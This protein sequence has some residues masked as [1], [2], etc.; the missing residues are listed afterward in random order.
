M[1]YVEAHGTGTA[2]GDPI[3]VQALSAVF[4]A[5]RETPLRLGS[6]KTNIGHLET[7]AGIAGLM[8]VV[9]AL[10]HEAIPPHLHLTRLNPHIS[11]GP[12]AEAGSHGLAAPI[13][14]PTQLTPWPRG[15]TPRLAGVS[16]FGFSGTNAHVIVE[17]APTASIANSSPVAERQL[18]LLALSAR[19]EAALRAV[20][21]RYAEALAT[22]PA[23]RLGDF[24]FS[25]HTGRA[26]FAHRLAV[27]G[28]DAAEI[29]QQLRAVHDGRTAGVRG[30]RQ[31]AAPVVFVFPRQGTQYAGMGRTLYDRE[32]VFR[33]ALDACAA[34]LAP[35]GVDLGALLFAPEAE[36]RLR[37]DAVAQPALV[38]S[39]EYALAQLWRAWGIEP[40]AV[41]GHDV[42]KLAAAIVSG[43]VT[44]DDA[45]R[46]AVTGGQLATD[47]GSSLPDPDSLRL[48]I[49]LAAGRDESR[50]VIETLAEL[51]VA[52]VDVDWAAYDAPYQRQRVP[53][54]TYPFQR[55][56]YW[57]ETVAARD[58]DGIHDETRWKRLT[59]AGR[60][61]ARAGSVEIAA[62]AVRQAT[63]NAVCRGY[64]RKALTELGVLRTAQRLEEVLESGRIMPR[65]AQL[66]ERWLAAL[67]DTGELRRD[68]A[69]F[70]D[71][72][73]WDA[74]AD[75]EASSV[76]EKESGPLGALV[77]RCGA[78]LVPVLRGELQPHELLFP[79]GSPAELAQLYAADRVTGY[80]NGIL[81]E[82][83]AQ[84]G[85]MTEPDR[86]LRVLEVG[87]GT[88]GT[89]TWVLPR[90]PAGRTTYMFTDVSPWFLSW[91]RE[92]FRGVP[93]LQFDV[94]DLERA[95]G[96]QGYAAGSYD[97]VIAANVLHATRDLR[98]TLQHVRALVAPG[99]LLLLY[100]ITAYQPLFD[101]IFG[102]VLPP[103][104]DAARRDAA[105]FLTQSEWRHALRDAGF[106]AVEEMC[107]EGALG[108]QVL[109]ARAAAAEAAQSAAGG[110][111]R[112]AQAN[113]ALHPVLGQRLQAAVGL[114]E[115][116][117]SL[118]TR[119]Y[120][121]EHQVY[122]AAV[123]PATAYVA[124][125]VAVATETA[126]GSP[127]GVVVEDLRLEAALQLEADRA[128]TVQV[129]VTPTRDGAQAVQV[130][131]LGP[132]CDHGDAWRMHA[133]GQVRSTPET[134]LPGHEPLEAIR[135]RCHEDVALTTFY[136]E[137][138]A[139]GVTYG[140][141]FQRLVALWRGPD[142][143]ALGE[144]E[145]PEGLTADGAWIH[146][147]VLDATWQVLGGGGWPART[148]DGDDV[149]V[150][151]GVE[152]VH[153]ARPVRGGRVWAHAVRRP[154]ASDRTVVGDVWVWDAA[155]Q[156]VGVVEG[157]TLQRVSRAQLLGEGAAVALADGR[158]E[159]VW[160]ARPGREGAAGTADAAWLIVADGGGVG[161]A[162]AARL[163]AARRALHDGR[164]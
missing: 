131:S 28:A 128:V 99:G 163:H 142:G 143:D 152:R 71:L 108:Q 73:P 161:A 77:R 155:G 55:Q 138:A 134:T 39:V 89:T 113:V 84:L 50:Q 67:V 30:E 70:V 137:W 90:L 17:E 24:C 111:A 45:L 75:L 52:G 122:G 59:A 121:S 51:Y 43:V 40:A 11:L 87:A 60:Q 118:T 126:G 26:A 46:L 114:Y 41:V 9:L 153:V 94:L 76:L 78:S 164:Q 34:L 74:A 112:L 7:A 98:R 158:Y 136:A 35:L 18:S 81:A 101:V 54:P 2:L 53:L 139:R 135:A 120:V 3:E 82:V 157:I 100:E 130:L 110:R 107:D 62:L 66:M 144:V 63:L 21:G 16:S 147:A 115:S 119:P 109:V 29:A 49:G 105:P 123:V 156:P 42:G 162:V 125:A 47:P 69:T 14:I 88:G 83:I 92:T 61:H 95:P 25:A 129:V 150:P 146:P 33:R 96:P 97:V 19:S 68:G 8:K 57:I 124:L 93:G 36:P 102:L 132:E 5:D 64:M 160:R 22:L 32:P 10:Q 116:Q 103:L 91:A 12:P 145:V 85:E 159:V 127:A 86:A 56:R 37:A 1:S 4:A 38:V 117:W 154:G 151:V 65:Y 6:V 140:P 72:R 13:E 58:L 79:G 141:M 149:Y 27:V 23:T 44:L 133:R 148:A 31:R 106:V 48:T 15:T 104:A 20:A 80:Y